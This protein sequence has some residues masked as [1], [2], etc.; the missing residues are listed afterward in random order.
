MSMLINNISDLEQIK[1]GYLEKVA[2]YSHQVLVCAGAGCVSSNCGLVRD[3]VNQEWVH[4][5]SVRLC[6]SFPKEYFTPR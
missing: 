6:S 1:S 4:A 3:A 5:L 2:K